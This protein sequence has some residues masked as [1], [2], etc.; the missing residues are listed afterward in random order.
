MSFFTGLFLTQEFWI[1]L[2]ILLIILDISVG[3]QFFV[4]SI[5]LSSFI[6]A[7]LLYAQEKLWS[8]DF[9]ISYIILSDWQD[10]LITLS[11]LSILT[12]GIIKYVF[13]NRFGKSKKDINDY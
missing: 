1:I 7:F 6:I 5:G 8:S 13:Q 2:G 4:L 9:N 12:V 10:V 11:I 3:F